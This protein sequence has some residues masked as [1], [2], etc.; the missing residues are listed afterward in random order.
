MAISINTAF[1]ASLREALGEEKLIPMIAAAGFDA[2]ELSLDQ[3]SQP[4]NIWDRIGHREY[5]LQLKATAETCGIRFN[6]AHAPARFDWMTP[7]TN[8]LNIIVYPYMEKAFEICRILE[9][10]CMVI[11][12]LTHPMALGLPSRRIPWNVTYFKHLSQMGETYGVK[13]AIKN[14][15]RTFETAEE[16]NALMDAVGSEN[17]CACVDTGHC[18]LS[19]EKAPDMIR[20]LGSRLCALHLNGNHGDFNQ[21]VIPGVDQLDWQPIL[22]A[23][24][25]TDYTGDFTLQVSE[26]ETG[27]L[28]GKHGFRADFLPCVL[29][30]A[31]ASCKHLAERAQI[32]KAQRAAQS[33]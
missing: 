33:E 22:E 13:V 6:Q 17:L 14:L 29:E 24:A 19:A 2:I 15:V 9:I 3:L 8:D 11:E 7:D 16:L 5:A 1:S 18:N 20:G 10:P 25:D 26:H 21:H 23:L 28:D 12:P 31:S 30:F 4:G 27:A 32:L